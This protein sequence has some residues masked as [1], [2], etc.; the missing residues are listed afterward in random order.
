[1]TCARSSLSWQLLIM[2]AM[3]SSHIKVD[4]SYGVVYSRIK[5]ALIESVGKLTLY[6]RKEIASLA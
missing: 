3:V 5:Q 1:M 6:C 4:Q 2:T